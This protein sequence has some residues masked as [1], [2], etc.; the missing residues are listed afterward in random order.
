[1][2]KI[3]AVM[4]NVSLSVGALLLSVTAAASCMSRDCEQPIKSVKSY[5]FVDLEGAKVSAIIVEYRQEVKA[6]SVDAAKYAITDYTILQEQ[7]NGYA[8]TIE[9]DRDSVKGNEGQ[10]ERVYVNDRPSPSPDGG[11]SQGRYVIIEVNTDYV[12]TGQNLV[13]QTTMMA[14]VRQT[15][16]IEGVSGTIAPGTE[17][18]GNYTTEQREGWGGRT[19]T[20]ITT[21]PAGIILP[22]FGEGSGWTIHR[23]GNGAYAA[24][25]CY[26]EYTGEYYDFELPYAI[27]VPKKEVLEANRGNVGLTIHMEHAGAN[28]TEPMAAITSS[29]AAVIHAGKEVQAIRPTIV[30]VP[31]I[32]ESRRTTNDLVASSEANA[33]IWQLINSVLTTYKGYIDEN[34]IYGTGQSMGGM[35]ILNMAA[36]RDNFFAGIVATGAQWSNNYDKTFQNGGQRTPDNDS[37]SFNGYGFDRENYQN[38]YYMVSD[39][40]I[41]VQTCTGDLMAFGEWKAFKEYYEAAGT[42]IPYSEWDPFLPIEEQEANGMKLLEHDT[43]K[44]GCGITWAGFNRG[45]HMSTWKYGYQVFYPFRW[46][47]AQTRQT[48]I[49]R[50][51]M[52]GLRNPWLGRDADGKVR[53]GSGTYR[54]NS[55]QFTPNGADVI[56]SENWTPV[57][58]T[59]KM[60]D[61]I[62]AEEQAVDTSQERRGPGRSQSRTDMIEQAK[63]AYDKLTN[64]EK[65][66]VTNYQ[67]LSVLLKTEEEAKIE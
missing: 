2:K 61:A 9:T 67:R 28:S 5:G 39:D 32:E 40:N 34:R 45:S 44:P 43:T 29:R 62:P 3:F 60:I 13:W 47:Y 59:I 14:G 18:V 16:A 35:C 26:S 55:A 48:E 56:Y 22:E 12:L 17:E 51:K 36:Q 53:K 30:L 21:D 41:L 27:Y 66:Q 33:A 37:S 50:E 24:K 38:W 64:A 20:V 7:Q 52:E 6:S 65:A 42:D 63:T 8:K 31:Q 58:A 11:T 1:M 49:L 54:L 57:S 10:I 4:L 25:H 15:E 19:Q 46:L 23:I